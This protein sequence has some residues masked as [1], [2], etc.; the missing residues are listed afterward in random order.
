MFEGYDQPQHHVAMRDGLPAAL[1]PTLLEEA[2]S[3]WQAHP[4]YAGKA[5]F[6][7]NIH[8]QLI[9]GSA[10]LAAGLEQL[11]DA[12]ES[13]LRDRLRAMNLLAGADHLIQFAHR[14]HEIEDHG[15]FPQFVQAYPQLERALGLMDSDHDILESALHGAEAGL[16][17]LGQGRVNRDAILSLHKDAKALNKVLTRHIADEEEVII[18][19]FL[20]HG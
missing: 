4:R 2:A 15:Y 9:D 18:P 3:D 19:I 11:S 10:Q 13:E 8:R 5:R 12:P 7:M 1:R 20:R 14:H 16:R 17:T 6:F